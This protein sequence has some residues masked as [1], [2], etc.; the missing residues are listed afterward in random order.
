MDVELANPAER[1]TD[2]EYDRYV[3]LVGLFRDLDY[4]G[5]RI[6][7]ASPFALQPVLFNSLLVQ[8][9]LD[10]AEIAQV[11]GEDPAGTRSGRS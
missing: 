2:E 6:Q 3:Y 7:D 8:A 4:R 10:L 9:N 1:P 11:L 5:D